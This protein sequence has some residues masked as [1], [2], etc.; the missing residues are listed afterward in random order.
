MSNNL[1]RLLAIL[2][3][4]ADVIDKAN[5]SCQFRYK[6][7]QR[8]ILETGNLFIK[9]LEPSPFRGKPKQCFQNCFE[10]LLR[11]SGFIYCE[12]YTIDD[13]LP[14]PILHAWLV[15]DASEVVDPTWNDKDSTGLTYFGVALNDEFVIDFSIRT[16][17]YGILESDYLSNYQ[18][19]REGFPKGALHS[20]FYL[21]LCDSN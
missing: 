1:E 4:Q 12:G 3:V 2:K 8:L 9:K 13:K 19:L 5:E 6:S 10:A 18:L 14:I 15:N 17:H 7:V 20:K 21:N 16:K 11:H